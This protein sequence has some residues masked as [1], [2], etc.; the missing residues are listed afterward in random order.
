[1]WAEANVSQGSLSQA[2]SQVLTE[3]GTR[4]SW[5]A[6]S[7]ARSVHGASQSRTVLI[8]ADGRDFQ[9]CAWFLISGISEP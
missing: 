8:G 5:W 7:H 4:G 2:H 9:W 1:M 3:V 6:G